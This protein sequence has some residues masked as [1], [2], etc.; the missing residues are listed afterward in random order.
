MLISPARAGANKMA[1]LI[2]PYKRPARLYGANDV[3][4]VSRP[5]VELSVVGQY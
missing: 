3:P 2:V 4:W 5:D 1:D